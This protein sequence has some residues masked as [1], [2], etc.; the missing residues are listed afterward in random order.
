MKTDN[1]DENEMDKNSINSKSYTSMRSKFKLRA[2]CKRK[3]HCKYG[4][5]KCRNLLRIYKLCFLFLSYRYA[6]VVCTYLVVDSRRIDTS[7]S[8]CSISDLS[9]VII[10]DK[11]P[12]IMERTKIR[13]YVLILILM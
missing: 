8:V 1:E 4:I 13:F 2:Y 7:K 11:D 9:T 12:G 5:L 10:L 3:I 6:V